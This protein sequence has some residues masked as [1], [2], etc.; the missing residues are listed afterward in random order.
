M[1]TT[2]IAQIGDTL[3]N[4]AHLHG[5][6]DCTALRSEPANAFIMQRATDAG[7][8]FPGDV[9]TVP[10]LVEKDESG[11]TEQ[12]HKFVKRSNLVS[13]RFVH[14]SPHLPYREDPTLINLNISNY[15]ANKAGAPDGNQAFPPDSV[16]KFNAAGHQDDDT[17][18]VE[19]TDLRAGGDIKVDLEVLK[20]VYTA[21]VVTGHT[22][23]PAAIRAD[24]ELKGAIASKQGASQCF[25]TCYLKL[26]TDDVDKAAAPTQTL[27]VSD[28]HAAGDS[29]VELLDQVVKASYEVP[30]CTQNPK[31]KATASLPIGNDRRRLRLAVHILR[32]FPIADFSG[33][34]SPVV[35]IQDM[36]KRIFTWLRRSYGQISIAPKLLEVRTVDPP[37]NLVSI[38]NDSGLTARGGGQ[39]SF[40]INAAGHPSQ[41]ITVNPSAADTP[42]TTANALAAQ[43]AAPFV[44]TVSENPARF[45]DPPGRK[46]A[47]IVITEAGG[48]RV[49]IDAVVSTDTRQTLTVGRPNPM[50][51][52]EWDGNNWLV[53]SIEQ[54]TVLKNYDTGDDRF[55][56]F[57]VQRFTSPNLLGAAMMS[58]HKVDP[59]RSAGSEAKWSAFIDLRSSDA[60]D[61]FPIVIAHELMHAVGEV[62]HTPG[63][64]RQ[65]MNPTANQTNAV[66]NSKR[67]RE[68]GV[69]YDGGTIAGFHNLFNRMRK[70]GAPLLE[71]W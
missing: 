50:L 71:S 51:F 65:I 43:I 6:N 59:Q 69:S 35:S 57:V 20:P 8:V 10:D 33:V 70:E 7:Q 29:E 60:S 26:V 62:M 61:S 24:R 19:V 13:I 58:G 28:M 12:K 46:S 9:V 4:I 16:R 54:R 44:A 18:K 14:G 63:S 36:E 47:D 38:S 52:Q 67:V 34:D 17:F 37:E 40:R 42:I 2:T 22:Q 41:T 32:L 21:G 27:L 30:T 55:D 48:A 31:C 66:N 3:C 49:T 11:S 5:F 15:V 56:L 39:L 45:V 53:G 68:G 25:R 23:F 1:P 64:P